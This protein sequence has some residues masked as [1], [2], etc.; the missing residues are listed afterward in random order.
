MKAFIDKDLIIQVGKHIGTFL[1]IL[2]RQDP[3][4]LRWMAKEMR[5]EVAGQAAFML[6]DRYSSD[7]IKTKLAHYFQQQGD[8]DEN[9]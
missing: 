9:A 4:Y 8:S 6:L 3:S 2:L 1:P 5:N 7:V